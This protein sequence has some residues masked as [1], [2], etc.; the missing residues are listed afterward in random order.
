MKTFN[1]SKPQVT[2]KEKSRP[3]VFYD[4]A[5][6][7]CSREIAHYRQCSGSDDINWLDISQS[8]EQLQ[9][10]EIDYDSA[11]KRFHVL[12]PDG[13]YHTG[14]FGFVYLWSK[15]KPYKALSKLI[16]LFSL[17]SLLDWFYVR[18]AKWR[19]KRK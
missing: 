1:L 15:L 8:K 13:T 17:A 18:F 2:S 12:S 16:N 4:G 19:T 9:A 14:A 11:M 7:L 6:P 5:C 3:T 10:Y